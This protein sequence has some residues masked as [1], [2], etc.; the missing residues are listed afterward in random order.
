[1]RESIDRFTDTVSNYL[2]YRPSYPVEI[3]DL[4]I[5]ECG[6]SSETIIAD[7]GSGTG[8]L[9]KLFLDNGNTVF[10]VEPN[11]KM[12]EAAEQ[13]LK[14][15]T[16]FQS[17]NGTAEATQL[18][19]A[20]ID[21]ITV[22]TAFHWFDFEKTKIE[23]KRILRTSGWVLLIWNLR[24]LENSPFMQEHEQLLVKYGVGYQALTDNNTYKLQ[25]APFFS[26]NVMHNCSFKH[27]QMFDWQGYQ[28]RLLSTSYISKSQDEKYN[29]MMA[30]LK[31]IFD[32]YQQN[33]QVKYEYLTQL[34]YGKLI[35]T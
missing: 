7:I 23:F 28:G 27:A 33:D 3:L 9:S 22:G 30:D 11:Q 29:D 1:M 10:G 14:H 26:P 18:K 12:R 16:G 24:A 5:K 32:K 21:L 19:D 8:I 2:K 35:S 15:Y 4:M 31:I 17:V 25:L 13:Q 20:S 6:L 34:Y